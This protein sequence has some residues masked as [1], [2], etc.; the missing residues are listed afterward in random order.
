[1]YNTIQ[2]KIDEANKVHSLFSDNDKLLVA[3]SGGADSVALLLSLKQFY[4]KLTLYACHVNHMLREQEADRDMDFVKELCK[5]KDITLEILKT[6]VGAY[7]KENGL[8]TELAA[9]NIRYEFFEA[10][11]RKHGINKVATAHTL[12]DNAETVLFNLA[13]GTGLSGL[14]GIP[15]K[16]KLSDS[17]FIIR[18][19]IFVKRDE[20]E[21]YL[22]DIGQDFVTDST[23]LTDDYTR[24]FFRHRIIPLFKEI[25][26]SFED[27]LKNTCKTAKDAQIFIDKTVNNNM[28]DDIRILA[29][30][31]DCVLASVITKL[32][33]AFDGSSFLESVHINAVVNLI[34]NSAEKKSDADEICLPGKI[35]A[36]I[37]NGRLIFRK[38]VRTKET[39]PYYEQ[40]LALG[41]NIIESTDYAVVLSENNLKTGIDG[42]ELL[43]KHKLSGSLLNGDLFVRNR[44]NGD[45]IRL[46]GMTKKLKSIFNTAKM[47]EKT[48]AVIPL[49]C[50]D[51]GIVLIPSVAVRDKVKAADTDE[52]N[53]LYIY[54][55]SRTTS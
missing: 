20:V 38:T 30:L 48:R 43:C 26:P 33:S 40:K 46:N 4:P 54:V 34:K 42:Y 7:A 47:P 39:V 24:N 23:N 10:V 25:N 27:A 5:A 31:D 35:S 18:P 6:D 12:S 28:T 41:L 9:R 45:T 44:K 2:C 15:A 29:T 51:D 52:N 17:I 37:E 53:N 1:M 55:Y 50:D 3:L 49:I 32:Y 13:R 8:S 16:R 14:C 22:K 19:L 36:V 21:A 11:C